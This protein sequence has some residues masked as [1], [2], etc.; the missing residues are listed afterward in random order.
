VFGLTYYYLFGA[1]QTIGDPKEPIGVR[2]FHILLSLIFFRIFVYSYQF[3]GKMLSNFNREYI[4]EYSFFVSLFIELF[5]GLLVIVPF[6]LMLFYP[7]M[8]V[9]NSIAILVIGVSFENVVIYPLFHMPFEYQWEDYDKI[10]FDTSSFYYSLFCLLVFFLS[11]PN[12]LNLRNVWEKH[13][14]Q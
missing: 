10:Q 5:G 6:G 8:L 3:F 12:W 7:F 11:I 4:K 14:N 2:Y 9:V 13:N 1:G